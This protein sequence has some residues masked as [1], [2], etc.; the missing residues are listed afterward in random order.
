MNTRATDGM[1]QRSWS[2]AF[3]YEHRQDDVANQM[4][5]FFPEHSV[6]GLCHQLP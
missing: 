3:Q 2:P 1:L 6:V 4:L 5:D